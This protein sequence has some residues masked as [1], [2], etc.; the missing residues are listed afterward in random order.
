MLYVI[1]FLILLIL[2]LPAIFIG[3]K[4]Y[5]NVFNIVKTRLNSYLITLIPFSLLIMFFFIDFV[6]T[7]LIYIYFC[8]FFL[9]I[10]L[11]LKLFKKNLNN[12]VCLGITLLI[13]TIF[14]IY[15]YYTN[16]NIIMTNYILETDKDI[17]VDKFRIVQITDSHLSSIID[18]NTFN[19]YMKK[20]NKLD[21]DIVVI[22]G[23]FVDDDTSLE[24]LIQGCK[25]L[26]QIKT[27]Y[28]IY[29][30]YGNHDKGYYDYRSFN[31]KRLRTELT[32]NNI[33]ILEDDVV[34]ITNDI[35]LIG[36]QDSSEK[37]RLNMS[38]ITEFVDKNKYMIVLDHKPDDYDNE[39]KE[40]VDLVLSGHAHGGQIFPIGQLS[41]L[42]GI[43]D[44]IY[45]LKKIKNTNFIVS[46]G[47]SDWKVKFK[48]GT[49][50][51]Y[52]VIDIV[53]KD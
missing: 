43:N 9:I 28:G 47:I 44:Q 51:E 4:I 49:V 31:D 1:I 53:K 7:L 34:N 5:K 17:K 37:D 36:R 8:F 2:I 13:T 30:V 41:V 10:N 14:F 23:D 20:I 27:K 19:K 32:K 25:G 3:K 29:F 21:P 35:L 42:L 38:E 22:T 18:G 6:N 26:G 12:F 33:V 50:S 39:Y 46:S 11:I 24:D 40:N 45:G 48:V 52:V 15:G 16:H